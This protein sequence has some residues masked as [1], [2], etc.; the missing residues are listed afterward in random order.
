M[1][2]SNKPDTTEIPELATAHG[3][4][5]IT[6]PGA[7]RALD[8]ALQAKV[9][10]SK[11]VPETETSIKLV[12]G[13]PTFS[14]GPAG[15]ALGERAQDIYREIDRELLL[16]PMIGGATDASFAARSGKAVALEAVGLAGF[17]YHAG[18][19]S[20]EVA[21]IVPRLYLM[22]RLLTHLGRQQIA[23]ALLT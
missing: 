7:E 9:A 15:R 14:A 16:V 19:E 11:L 17:G 20:I 5:R 8:T 13:H 6:V 23:L 18:D 10:S 22:T 21:S 12:L 4:V 2:I 3:D 1:L